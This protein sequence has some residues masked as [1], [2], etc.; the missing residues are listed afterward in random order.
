MIDTRLLVG[1][2]EVDEPSM[3]IKP[4]ISL[5]SWALITSPAY[6]LPTVLISPTSPV[7]QFTPCWPSHLSRATCWPTNPVVLL[8]LWPP[9]P[10]LTLTSPKYAVDQS[11]LHLPLKQPYHLHIFPIIDLLFLHES[12]WQDVRLTHIPRCPPKSPDN[13]PTIYPSREQ[14]WD[15]SNKNP[16]ARGQ[17]FFPFWACE[18]MET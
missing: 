10:S 1:K 7:D 2:W 17:D 18:W 12:P 6:H 4:L 15:E 9:Y 3:T 13:P 11:T 5:V 16:G 8:S 14:S